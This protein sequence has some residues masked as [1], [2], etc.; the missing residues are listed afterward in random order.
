MI[1]LTIVGSKNDVWFNIANIIAVTECKGG[2]TSVFT[3]DGEEW[4]VLEDMYTVLSMIDR[5][6]K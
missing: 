3:A 1:G 5:K 6:L 4:I 2:G